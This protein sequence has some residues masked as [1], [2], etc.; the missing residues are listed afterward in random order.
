MIV[1]DPKG[2]RYLRAVLRDAAAQAGARFL[3]W[4]PTGNYV[5]NP[6][7]RGGPTEIADKALAGHKCLTLTTS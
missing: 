2:D 3:E 4:S 7:G 6:F 5:Y 1:L